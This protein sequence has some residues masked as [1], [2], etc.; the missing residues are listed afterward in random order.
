VPGTPPEV[1]AGRE[2][3]TMRAVPNIKKVD[4]ECTKIYEESTHIW[5]D[6]VEYIEMKDV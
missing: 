1:R 5:T 2:R 3:K 6:L 4:E